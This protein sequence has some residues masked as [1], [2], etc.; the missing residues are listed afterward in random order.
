MYGRGRREKEEGRWNP[1][2]RIKKG[3]QVMAAF[4]VLGKKEGLTFVL[5]LR[6]GG[7]F[8]LGAVMQG[9]NAEM[10]LEGTAEGEERIEAELLTHLRNRALFQE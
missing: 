4:F 5:F 10:R 9:A 8:G 2:L 7:F 3:S 6:I 1:V